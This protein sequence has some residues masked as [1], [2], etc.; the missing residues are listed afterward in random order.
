LEQE[1]QADGTASLSSE[2]ILALIKKIEGRDKLALSA[3]YDGTGRLLFG[4]VLRILGDR[5]LAE[6]T[7]LDVYTYVWRQ[8]ASYDPRIQPVEWLVTLARAR[9]VG[10]L[11]WNKLD[12]GRQERAAV[13]YGPTMTVV[14]EQQKLARSAIESLVSVQREILDW[15]YY[16]GLSCSEIAA[17]SGKPLGAVKTHARLGLSKLIELLRPLSEHETK[18][19]TETRGTQ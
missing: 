2:E 13:S 17:L 14:P 3:L 19:K 18:A 16:S 10:R 15:A 7:L 4:L 11:H 8:P 6:E 9:A 1:A 5:A 12:K